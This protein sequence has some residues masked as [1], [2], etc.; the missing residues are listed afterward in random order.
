M[1]RTVAG[2]TALQSAKTGLRRAD[3]S[4]KAVCSAKAR[5]LAGGTMEQQQVGFHHRVER[6][7]LHAG[8]GGPLLR[9]AA[10]RPLRCVS[11]V[12]PFSTRRRA[13]PAPMFPAATMATTGFISYLPSG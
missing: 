3:F 1:W 4:A 9:V 8:L 13:I 11:T 5:A 10:L 2:L 12:T 7:G 6:G